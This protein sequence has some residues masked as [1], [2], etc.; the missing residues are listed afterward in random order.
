MDDQKAVSS[1]LTCFCLPQFDASSLNEL[2]L[3]RTTLTILF[4]SFSLH[5]RQ[6]SELK[7]FLQF[8]MQTQ[9]MYSGLSASSTCVVNVIADCV[10]C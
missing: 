4:N 3:D 10:K 9:S 8:S 5:Q 2:V 7:C 6:C 1:I